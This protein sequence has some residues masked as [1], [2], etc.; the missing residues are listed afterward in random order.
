[1]LNAGDAHLVARAPALPCP[2]AWF[3]QDADHPMLVAHRAQGG[4]TCGAREG[5]L[6]LH[7]QDADHDLGAVVDLPLTV[8]GS[9]RYNL[10]NLA[11]AALLASALGVSVPAIARVAQSFGRSRHDN[12]GRLERWDLQGVTVLMDYAH[13]LEGLEGLLAVAQRLRGQGR[14][15]LLLGQAGNREDDAIR[16]LV[17]CVAQAHPSF[18]V[19][20]DLD[21]YL[22]G[23]NPGDVPAILRDELLRLGVPGH[24]LSTILS[25][26]AAAKAALTWAR[27]G[28]VVVLPVHALSAREKVAAMLDGLVEAGWMPGTPVPQG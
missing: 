28:D 25:E 23:R 20:K 13:N 11:G 8:L 27:P 5:R 15:G 6:V 1:V 21:G 12:P 10:E 24:K 9:A 18:I 2:L 4:A 26:A 7:W 17:P 22:R 14:L 16:A 3:A 19:L